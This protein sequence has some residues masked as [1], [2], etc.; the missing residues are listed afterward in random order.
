MGGSVMFKFLRNR[1]K[2]EALAKHE[3]EQGLSKPKC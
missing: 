3:R 1:V 2:V